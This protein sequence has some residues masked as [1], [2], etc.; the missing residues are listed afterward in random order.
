MKIKE[1]TGSKVFQVVIYAIISLIM[2]ACLYPF[3]YI[4]IISVS[5]GMSVMQGL[6]KIFPVGM[7]FESYKIVLKDPNIGGAYFNTILYTIVGT[8]VNII[9][10][11]LCAYPLSRKRFFGRNIFTIMIV[12]T[13][14]FS[15]GM[16]P[17]YLVVQ[18]L[19]MI[20][21]IWALVLPGAI[22]TYNMIIM[23]TFFNGIPESL[24]ES[25]Y[26]DGA[27]DVQIFSKIILPLSLPVIATMIL[28]YSVG[29][30]NAF[31][32]ALIYI[33]EKKKLPLQVIIRN[34]V[35][36]G[37]LAD[38][39]ASMGAASNFVTTDTTIKYALIMISTLPILV[40]YP[41][42]QKYF[43]KGVMV[44]SLKG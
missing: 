28:F 20:N 6:V 35:I 36:S 37:D 19:H 41:F 14:F 22:N 44:G 26:I 3:Y 8:I 7:N 42:V 5:N 12:F 21:T 40:I 15:G 9:F 11:T 39:N 29:H 10:T 25:A 17:S 2:V 43:V 31:F 1:S 4:A 30:W 38:Q 33:N 24:H 18:N 16:I 13:M 27:N 23:R 32:A 34:M